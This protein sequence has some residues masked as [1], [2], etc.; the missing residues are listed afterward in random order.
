M[1]RKSTLGLIVA[2]SAA[3][4]GAAFAQSSAKPATPATPSSAST[5]KQDT[6]MHKA[7]AAKAASA[8]PAA[9]AA[10]TKEQ[11]KTAQVGLTKAGLY[12]GD[13][14][15]VMNAATHKAIRAYQK[16]NKM[17]ATGR[18]SDSLLTKLGS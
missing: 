12:K 17:P 4:A 18:L 9:K 6:T 10:W 7:H 8:K 5:M 13:T 15:G 16:Q 2:L 11:I 14:N 1:F 3:T